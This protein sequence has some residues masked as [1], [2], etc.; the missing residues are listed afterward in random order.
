MFPCE[1]CSIYICTRGNTLS[2]A[3]IILTP[4]VDISEVICTKNST[5]NIKIPHSLLKPSSF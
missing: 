4:D 2:G 3:L 1:T 5:T